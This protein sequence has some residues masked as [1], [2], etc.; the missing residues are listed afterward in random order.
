[1][2]ALAPVQLVF[3]ALVV[4]AAFAV[5][6]TTGFGGNAI[7]VPLLTLMLPI[8]MVLAVMTILVVFSSLGHWVKDWRKIVWREILRVA[9]FTLTGVLVGL[10]LFQTLDA[11]TLTRAFGVF[12]M[13]YAVFA[14]ATA[15]RTVSPSEKLLWPMAVAM[16]TLAGL[17]GTVFGGAA[18]P[19]YVIY[20]NILQLG[21]DR[22]RVTITTILMVQ[23]AMRI[24]GYVMLGFYDAATL[25]TLAAALPLMLIGARIGD[26]LATRINQHAF[27]RIVG[28][29]LMVSG[30]V[31][32][33]K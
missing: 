4:T 5:R 14:M 17:V 29:V 21:K 25:L 2:E 33:F 12:V 9:P 31:L 32:L 10:H 30:A 22:F 18:G 23:A 6:G 20:L 27:N 26:R 3:C 16:S 11:R 24:A 8:Q 28:G 13:A 7:A 19:L 15:R 1:M